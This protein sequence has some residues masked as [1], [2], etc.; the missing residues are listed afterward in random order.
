MSV[1]DQLGL[2]GSADRALARAAESWPA[3]VGR[4]P[5]LGAVDGALGGLRQWLVHAPA[6]EADEV[7]HALAQL[8]AADGGDNVD[9]AL[10]LAWT[11]LPGARTVARR[12]QSLSTRIDEVVASQLW[13]EVRAFPWRRLRKVAANIIANTRAGALLE[14]GATPRAARVDPWWGRTVPVD[15]T[16]PFWTS[17][18]Q[19]VIVD[20]DPADEL[21]TLLLWAVHHEVI[22]EQDRAL[23]LGVVE[24]AT[25]MPSSRVSSTGG[26]ATSNAAARH[27]AVQCGISPATLRRR[28]LS[29][30]AAL[31]SVRVPAPPSFAP[32]AEQRHSGPAPSV[33]AEPSLAAAGL[34]R[35]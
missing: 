28:L 6:A 8:A 26:L 15:P 17:R 18:A 5:R 27:V 4:D 24:A 13:I 22:G 7:L 11:L 16:G 32:R 23:L 34:R 31:S 19:E 30:T 29:T 2:T 35:R 20:R 21:N 10:V 1:A 9:A 33:R 25:S 3:W 14:L 12:L